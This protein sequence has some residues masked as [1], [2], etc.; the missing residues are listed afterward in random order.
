MGLHEEMIAMGCSAREAARE[1]RD[2]GRADSIR[3]ALREQGWMI[4]DTPDGAR[5]KPACPDAG[6]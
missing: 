2:F 1:A 3:E 6:V 4:E 5:I